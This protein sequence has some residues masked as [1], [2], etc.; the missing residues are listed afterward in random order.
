M[1]EMAWNDWIQC[2]AKWDIQFTCSRIVIRRWYK[3]RRYYWWSGR[4]HRL[5]IWWRWKNCVTAL[6]FGEFTA[7]YP[8]NIL[9]HEQIAK[10]IQCKFVE[11]NFHDY[12]VALVVNGK[13][14]VTPSFIYIVDWNVFF[15][16]LI[17]SSIFPQTNALCLVISLSRFPYCFDLL[18]VIFLYF[19]LFLFCLELLILTSLPPKRFNVN[20][21]SLLRSFYFIFLIFRTYN[22]CTKFSS[23]SNNL[24]WKGKVS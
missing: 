23:N 12:D 3:L 19:H 9:N 24:C 22:S 20:F 2:Y 13:Y 10:C 8:I 1:P 6:T 11:T 16:V 18:I 4:L 14:L 5:R 7:I 21:C 15:F 17:T